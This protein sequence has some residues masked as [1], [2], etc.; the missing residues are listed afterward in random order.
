MNLIECL[1]VFVEVGKSLNFSKAAAS[2]GVS[3]STV[4]KKIAWL[5]AHFEVQLLN[6][7]TKH[8]SLTESGR[9]L[10]EN[11]DML[12]QSVRGLKELVQ[13]PVLTA[14]GRIRI[15]TPP[16]FGAVHLAPAIEDFLRRYPSIKVSLLLDDGRSDLIAE[17]LDL[18]V[19]IAPRLKDTN[20]IAYRITVVPQVVVAT[21]AYLQ[22][23]GTPRT[24]AD[25]ERHNCLV[26]TLKAPTSHWTFTDSRRATHVVR[27]NG[28]FS[29]NLGESIQNLAR[30]GHGIAMHPRYMVESD[31]AAGRLQVLLPGYEPQ[32]LDIYA[33][34]Q[35]RRNLPHKVRL[36]VKHLRAW[37]RD[38]DWKRRPVLE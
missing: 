37:F 33:I 11:A 4:T 34:V 19:R 31:I 23:H 13:G 27:V 26:H 36:F 17:N 28:S 6:R 35:T 18:S 15:G 1:D 25:L 7:N 5:E 14:S 21:S 29:S 9:L 12:A 32:G 38:A 2:L 16:S 8:V 3:N 30:L 20:Q 22:A 24:P 10:L